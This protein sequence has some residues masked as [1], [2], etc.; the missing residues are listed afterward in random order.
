MQVRTALVGIV[1]A[2]AAGAALAQLYRW[3]D[4]KG[5]THISDT[6]PPAS[7][8]NVQKKAMPKSAA[9]EEQVHFE[10]ALAMKDFPVV[11]YTSPKCGD[12]CG[13]AR[14]ALNKR[15][16]PFKE[17]QVW[18]QETAEELKKVSGAV[19]VPTTLVG[20]QTHV[21]FEQAVFDALLDSAGYPRAGT[22]PPLQQKAP[23]VPEGYLSQDA[24]K[25]KPAAVAQPKPGPY[26]TSGLKGPP[27]KPGQY[28]PSGL[29]GPPPK[30]GQ[31]GVP[32][33]AAPAETK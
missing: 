5:R 20:R 15:G 6:P 23:P 16:V 31:Y 12:L 28:D 19:E 21:G 32:G 8:K 13:Q 25:P 24:P 2:S 9:P 30:P 17:V 11:L 29:T 27:P 1:L 14:E 18:N 22:V 10:V 33:E 7:A 3:T 4:E 26:D